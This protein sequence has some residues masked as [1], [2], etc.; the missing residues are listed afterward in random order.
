MSAPWVHLCPPTSQDDAN[1]RL[2]VNNL[3]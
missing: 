1:A 2:G 3:S